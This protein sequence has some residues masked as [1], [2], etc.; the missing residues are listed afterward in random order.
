MVVGMSD[1]KIIFIYAGEK[2]RKG[3]ENCIKNG[4]RIGMIER[5]EKLNTFF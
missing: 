4:E 3:K 2:I 5:P 1:E